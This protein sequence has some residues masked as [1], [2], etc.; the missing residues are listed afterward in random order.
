MRSLL[1][2][3]L[4]L[5]EGDDVTSILASDWSVMMSTK[6]GQEVTSVSLDMKTMR[7]EAV[8]STDSDLTDTEMAE[9]KVR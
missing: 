8:D 4:W 6:G 9:S 2:E 3:S 5:V 1:V 7:A